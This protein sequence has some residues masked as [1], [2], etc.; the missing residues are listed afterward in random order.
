MAE[1]LHLADGRVWLKQHDGLRRRVLLG[2]LGLTARALRVPCLRP[3]PRLSALQARDVELRRL[4]EL[5][6]R[7]IPV[8]RV[9][10]HSDSALLL[11]DGGPSLAHCLRNA[12]DH[13]AE[14]LLRQAARQLLRAHRAG[15]CI[16]Q[17]VARNIT[18]AQ[19]G[20][21]RFIDLED[22]PLQV[23][24]LAQAQARDWLLFISGSIR[25]APLPVGAYVA[26]I[27]HCLRQ[28]TPEVQQQLREAVS[29]LRYLP[30]LCRLG[31]HRAQGVGRSVQVLRRALA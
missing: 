16:G 25:H 1:P 17:P 15:C 12:D 26:V 8:P 2:T 5:A 20:Q 28:A 11:E 4:L 10:G 23:M 7:G 6:E 29:R 31:G 13:K 19:D 21:L 14:A 30:A 24:D 27:G 18:V 22:D 3:P 9:L